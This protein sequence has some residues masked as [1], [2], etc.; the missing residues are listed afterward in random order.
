MAKCYNRPE[1][2][3]ISGIIQFSASHSPLPAF[4]AI[5][6]VGASCV[7]Q[8]CLVSL[9]KSGSEAR[10][11]SVPEERPILSDINRAM[12]LAPSWAAASRKEVSH[13]TTG[14]CKEIIVQ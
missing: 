2:S 12:T 8:R 9:A 14:K 4:T 6:Y 11:I 10:K 13:A 1:V 5:R 3:G 7:V